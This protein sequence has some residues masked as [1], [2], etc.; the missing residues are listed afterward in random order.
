VCTAVPRGI[1]ESNSSA[2]APASFNVVDD[3]SLKPAHL[4]DIAE[5]L[6]DPETLLVQLEASHVIG[7]REVDEDGEVVV[8]APQSRRRS[9]AGELNRALEVRDAVEIT[10]V[11]PGRADGREGVD[12]ELVQREAVDQLECFGRCANRFLVPVVKHLEAADLGEDTSFLGR[13]RRFCNELFGPAE[14]LHA[15]VVASLQPPCFRHECLR[16]SRPTAIAK[17]EQG[18][19]RP[20]ERRDPTVVAHPEERQSLYSSSARTAGRFSDRSSASWKK[21]AAAAK[22]FRES[23]RSPASAVA[24]RALA[25]TSDGTSVRAVAIRPSADR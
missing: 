5:P 9:P 1:L 25:I 8:G 23:A 18:V 22:L 24:T 19:S 21:R 16:N 17:L 14:M 13:R 20:L 2:K 10:E 3:L 11:A 6:C 15:A 12:P 7:V 4:R